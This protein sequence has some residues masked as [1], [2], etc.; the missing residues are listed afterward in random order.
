MVVT[1]SGSSVVALGVVVV[2]AT[3]VVGNGVVVVGNGVVVVVSITS[4]VPDPSPDPS[5]PEPAQKKLYH[6]A[7]TLQII[8]N[9]FEPKC[10]ILTSS[11]ILSQF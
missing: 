7:Q 11:S 9:H 3:V 8:L 1:I 6:K 10:M 5:S 4:G 2:S